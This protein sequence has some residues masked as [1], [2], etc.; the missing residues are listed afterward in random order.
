MR[1]DPLIDRLS[2]ELK[3][4]RRRTALSD[5]IALVVLAAV[6]LGLFLALRPMRPDMPMAMHLP[7]FWWKL[8]SLGLIA[9]VSGA[10]AIVS[11]DPV[12]SPR[13]GLRWIVALIAVC[14][15]IGWI[16]DASRDGFSALLSRLDWPNGLQCLEKIMVLSVPAVIGLGLL[17]RRGAPTDRSGT[18]LAAGLAAAAW[19]AFVF[20]FAC[21]FDDPFYVAV[22]YSLGCG[23]LTLFARFALPP[24]TRW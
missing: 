21:P 9:F 15:A 2:T 12:R 18:A 7:S 17:M 16:L 24:L 20:V 19:G 10:V 13:R 4:V 22:W 8:A 14:L 3:P 1:T 23:A 6:E 11:L 5:A